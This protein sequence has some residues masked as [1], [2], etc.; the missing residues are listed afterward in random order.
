MSII[1]MYL[2]HVA[3][4]TEAIEYAGALQQTC[5]QTTHP[6]TLQQTCI[7]TTHPGTLQQTCI[8]TTHTGTKKAYKEHC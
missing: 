2:L 5:I 6:G 7:Q 1:Y 3:H 8:H 4:L